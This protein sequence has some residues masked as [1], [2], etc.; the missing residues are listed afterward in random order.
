MLQAGCQ[1]GAQFLRDGRSIGQPEPIEKARTET[2]VG[3][4]LGAQETAVEA[5]T[6]VGDMQNLEEQIFE[7]LISANR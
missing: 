3:D 1:V 7:A 4:A 2:A 5:R 6:G